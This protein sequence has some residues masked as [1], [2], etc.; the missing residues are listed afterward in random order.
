MIRKQ[1]F[2]CTRI[3]YDS[4]SSVTNKKQKKYLGGNLI[5]WRNAKQLLH[6]IWSNRVPNIYESIITILK[7]IN[8]AITHMFTGKRNGRRN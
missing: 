7:K 1:K 3:V 5:N 4:I 6:D 2:L 8:S